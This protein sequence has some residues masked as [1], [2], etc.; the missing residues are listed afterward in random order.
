MGACVD[1]S[2]GLGGE[3]LRVLVRLEGGDVDVSLVASPELAT[4]LAVG[5]RVLAAR[6]AARGLRVRSC[7]VVTATARGGRR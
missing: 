1:V 2:V 4:A 5:G 7:R 6:L 3:R